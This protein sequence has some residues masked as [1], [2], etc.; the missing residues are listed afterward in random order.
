MIRKIYVEVRRQG[1]EGNAHE[2]ACKYFMPGV[3]KSIQAIAKQPADVYPVWVLFTNGLAKSSKMRQE[4]Q[5]WF[6]G[7]ERN[8]L[9]WE[10]FPDDEIV[11]SH[12]EQHIRPL[13]D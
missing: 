7:I 2:R 6:R 5:H 8:V 1:D 12:F 11:I 13:L 3:V 10:G 9:L 4:I